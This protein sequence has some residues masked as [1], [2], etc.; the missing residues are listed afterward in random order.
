MDKQFEQF[1][2]SFIKQYKTDIFNN[3]SKCK[4]LLLDNAKGEYKKEIRLLLQALEIGF[5]SSIINSTDLNLTR[6]TLIKQFQEEY[7]ISEEVAISLI[8]LLLLELKKYKVEQI[9]QINIS[10]SDKKNSKSKINKVN[11]K[12]QVVLNQNQPI[13]K[14]IIDTSAISEFSLYLSDKEKN[15]KITIERF[16][17]NIK[18]I[19]EPT[20]KEYLSVMNGNNLK[21]IYKIG[22]DSNS[23]PY[24][25]FDFSFVNNIFKKSYQA[26]Y[27]IYI[28]ND[29]IVFTN[30][31]YSYYDYKMQGINGKKEY[32]IELLTKEVIMNELILFTEK[33][34]SII[35]EKIENKN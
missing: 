29:G 7:Y 25:G 31:Y 34:L 12:E 11:T 26:F 3:I 19:Y 16:N 5:Y 28:K 27:G 4:S 6:M 9:N 33:I 32:K 1:I 23:N 2:H 21:C 13:N 8:D 24:I 30:F 10:K 15:K 22:L 14:T 35:K 20:F 17:E 18:S